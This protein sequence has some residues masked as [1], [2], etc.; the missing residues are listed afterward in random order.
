[1]KT[2]KMT[3]LSVRDLR[4]RW[5]PIKEILNGQQE[6]HPTAIRVHRVFSWMARVEGPDFEDYLDITLICR[7]IAFNAMYG[8]WNEQKREGKQRSENADFF[9]SRFQRHPRPLGL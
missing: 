3:S 1:M 5:K 4:R 9:T 7:W 8:Q 2:A 6:G